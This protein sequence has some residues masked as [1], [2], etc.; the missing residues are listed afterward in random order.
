MTVRQFV[1]ALTKSLVCTG[2][3]ASAAF[4]DVD[5]VGVPLNV[6][7]W[8]DGNG[9]LGVTMAGYSNSV[10]ILCSVDTTLGYVTATDCKN[11]LAVLLAAIAAQRNVDI[12]FAGYTSCASVPSFQINLASQV[13]Y[14]TAL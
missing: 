12:L 14:V 3:I 4:A 11:I 2:I 7:N 10:W 13:E 9:Y 1:S 8:E 5:C 6:R